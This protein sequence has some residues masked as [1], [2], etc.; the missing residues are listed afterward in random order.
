MT[1][2]TW[3]CAAAASTTCM[4]CAADFAAVD[5]E[6]RALAV[7][8]GGDRRPDAAAPRLSLV[9]SLSA[10]HSASLPSPQHER[11]PVFGCAP[12][13]AS[14]SSARRP[15]ALRIHPAG[16]RPGAIRFERSGARL[17][18]A[19]EAFAA[20]EYRDVVRAGM[21]VA[22]RTARRR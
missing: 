16:H 7:V 22:K 2:A 9:N 15:A 5:I 13:T 17:E 1:G 6:A 11:A 4:S 10:A 12:P 18:L 14:S 3:I 21:I 20:F 8:G 19:R